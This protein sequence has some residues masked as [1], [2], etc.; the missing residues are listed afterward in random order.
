MA[1]TISTSHATDDVWMIKN[2]IFSCF[3]RMVVDQYV[4]DPG[5]VSQVE[6]AEAMNGISLDILYESQPEL[7]MRLR[8]ALRAVANRIV[9]GDLSAS[10][11]VSHPPAD[12]LTQHQPSFIPLIQLLD[13]WEPK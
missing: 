13:R 5:I 3:A 4:H 12:V 11:D 10:D 8:N 9:R 7:A 2:S 1:C 6:L